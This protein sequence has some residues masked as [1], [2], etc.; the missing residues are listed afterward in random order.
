MGTSQL[1]R[2][3]SRPQCALCAVVVQ[4]FWPLIT[5]LLPC[6]SARVTAPAMSEPLP[7]SLKSWHQVSS[8][9]RMRRRN[10]SLCRSVPCVEDRGGGQR[11][12]AG[13]GDAD[14]ADAG[15]LLVDDRR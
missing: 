1:V 9:V 4:T 13:L 7:G 6:R 12:D 14:G 5:H 8:P 2:A 15:E 11:A 3:S 10:F